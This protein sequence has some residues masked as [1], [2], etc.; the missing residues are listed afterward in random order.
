MSPTLFKI[1]IDVVLKEWVQ[2]C[3][4]MR[5]KIGDKYPIH[6]LFEDDQVIMTQNKEDLQHV[7]KEALKACKRWDLKINFKKTEC[8][9]TGI[10]D[11][12]FID[13]L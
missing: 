12:F 9:T 2:Q 13:R 8:M 7:T 5:V 1:Y 11:D 10:E 4:K 3:G 6:L